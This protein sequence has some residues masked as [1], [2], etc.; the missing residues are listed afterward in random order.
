MRAEKCLNDFVRFIALLERMGNGIGTRVFI[1]G[2]VV[3]LGDFLT[4]LANDLWVS[5]VIIFMEG[6]RSS[7]H[8]GKRPRCSPCSSYA[9]LP[10]C[11]SESLKPIKESTHEKKPKQNSCIPCT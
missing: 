3:V 8:E 2:M 7:H 9:G 6:F 5:T 4:Y 10:I 11:K 1:W